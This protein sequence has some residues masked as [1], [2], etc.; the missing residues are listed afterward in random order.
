M[1]QLLLRFCVADLLYIAAQLTSPSSLEAYFSLTLRANSWMWSGL[2]TSKGSLTHS[3]CPSPGLILDAASRP[4]DYD[5]SHNCAL[6]SLSKEFDF[7][8]VTAEAPGLRLYRIQ[9]LISSVIETTLYH[10][11]TCTGVSAADDDAA[12]GCYEL[13]T[14]LVT[15]A[16]V[17]A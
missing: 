16:P 4:A 3:A 6:L 9:L 8:S 7:A 17:T 14:Q 10:R 15:E 11:L 13:R 1:V 5:Q 12:A 2:D